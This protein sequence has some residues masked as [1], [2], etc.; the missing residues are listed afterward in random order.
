[1]LNI[2]ENTNI[3]IG[4]RYNRDNKI[5]QFRTAFNTNLTRKLTIGADLWYDAKGGGVRDSA[6]R[7]RLHEQCWGALFTLQRKPRINDSADYSM[8][9]LVEL[10]G[11]GSLGKK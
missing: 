10:A 4:E 6:L 5:M 11:I 2:T 8:Y 9:V 7:M 1:N 3:S